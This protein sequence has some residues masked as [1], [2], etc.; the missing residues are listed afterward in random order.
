MQQQEVLPAR[1]VEVTRAILQ[2]EPKLVHYAKQE[3][4]QMGEVQTREQLVPLVMQVH[5]VMAHQQHQF[6]LLEA[7]H[8]KEVLHVLPVERTRAIL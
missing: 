5:P 4:I 6:A 3:A 2:L 8:R 1:L 7:L